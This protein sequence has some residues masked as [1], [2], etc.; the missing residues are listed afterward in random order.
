MNDH[1]RN[2]GTVLPFALW[3]YHT[4]ISL[5]TH[6]TPYFLL[7]GYHPRL[8]VA[9]LQD[10]KPITY[11][12]LQRYGGELSDKIRLLHEMVQKELIS[13]AEKQER[14]Y[15]VK[16]S[17]KDFQVGQLCYLHTPQVKPG[18]VKKLTKLSTGLYRIT[19]KLSG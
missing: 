14:Y 9:V 4:S 17:D 6:E 13:A 18:R 12:S 7:F 8:P 10:D 19:A 3:S 16:T 5:T 2:W 15:N 1:Q 11:A